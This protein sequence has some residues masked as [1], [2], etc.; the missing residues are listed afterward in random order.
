[1]AN[2][3]LEV[4]NQNH[5]KKDEIVKMTKIWMEILIVSKNVFVQFPQDA[6]KLKVYSG[7]KYRQVKLINKTTL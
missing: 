2:E 4:D 6:L 7:G 3:K 5:K 1:M